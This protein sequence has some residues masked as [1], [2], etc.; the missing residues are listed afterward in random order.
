MIYT[1]YKGI[2]LVLIKRNQREGGI[3]LRS[4]RA[5][6]R[7]PVFCD[8]LSESNT[9]L[10]SFIQVCLVMHLHKGRWL[11]TAYFITQQ[12]QIN[13]QISDVS[14]KI[15]VSDGETGCLTY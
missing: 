15:S 2:L 6:S 3:P 9:S 13:G 12:S 4:G 14:S 10:A 1:Y 11:Y 8:R 7:T 5:G